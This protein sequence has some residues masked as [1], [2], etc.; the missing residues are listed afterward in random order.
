[1]ADTG[2]ALLDRL[3]AM[4]LL[5]PAQ[6]RRR[7]REKFYFQSR[8]VWRVIRKPL[9]NSVDRRRLAKE[10]REYLFLHP[11]VSSSYRNRNKVPPGIGDQKL[12]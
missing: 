9:Y 1:M 3:L 8:D 7:V 4:R 5:Q 11:S 10:A 2:G 12:G 6:P